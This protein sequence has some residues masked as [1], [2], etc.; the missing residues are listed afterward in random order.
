MHRNFGLRDILPLHFAQSFLLILWFYGVIKKCIQP[1][2]IQ[3]VHIRRLWRVLMV[4][5][6]A[7]LHYSAKALG[8]A[9]V[10]QLA[11]AQPC[12]G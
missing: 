2:Y 8:F 7:D 6:F 9:G 11:R 5:I 10:A 1:E 3:H 4:E 12:Q